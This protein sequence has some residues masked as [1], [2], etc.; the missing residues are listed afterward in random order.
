M[1]ALW[2]GSFAKCSR[3]E[4]VKRCFAVSRKP[5]GLSFRLSLVTFST[6][7]SAKKDPLRLIFVLR[8]K[9]PRWIPF[10]K[11]GPF[12][13]AR[14]IHSSENS[15]AAS[16]TEAPL[17]RFGKASPARPGKIFPFQRLL[18][19][20]RTKNRTNDSIDPS[21]TWKSPRDLRILVNVFSRNYFLLPLFHF[22]IRR[23]RKQRF[24]LGRLTCATTPRAKS[25]SRTLTAMNM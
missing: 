9:L 25:A 21:S 3:P 6:S 8:T 7:A 22:S 23:P 17:T 20:K 13:G 11:L 15:S 12:S 18:R 24:S 10:L 2:E 14:L 5:E 4:R 1:L 19:S 16:L